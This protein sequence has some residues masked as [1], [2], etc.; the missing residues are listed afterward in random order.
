MKG[1]RMVLVL[2]FDVYCKGIEQPDTDCKK[3]GELNDD[4]NED[5]EADS[6]DDKSD[7]GEDEE[8]DSDDDDEDNDDDDDE[9]QFKTIFTIFFNYQMKNV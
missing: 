9:I 2:Q 8:D 7:D 3:L 1:V 5:I 4:D 6:I